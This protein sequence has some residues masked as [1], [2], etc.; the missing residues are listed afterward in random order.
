MDEGHEPR[1]RLK[2]E[3][4]GR[5][6]LGGSLIRPLSG[7]PSGPARGTAALNTPPFFL[8]IGAKHA[9]KDRI[10]SAGHREMNQVPE[11]DGLQA[12]PVRKISFIEIPGVEVCPDLKAQC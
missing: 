2:R 11:A 5:K 7:R 12:F 6:A 1:P 8:A 9:N 4:G 10:S 3:T